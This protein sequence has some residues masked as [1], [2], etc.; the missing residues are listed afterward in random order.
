[1]QKKISIIVFLFL[2]IPVFILNAQ[3]GN[4]AG[5][6]VNKD[7]GDALP[8]VNVMI[9]ELE[10]GN[11]TQEGGRFLIE[12]VPTGTY[13]ITAS[14]IGYDRKTKSVTVNE[15]LTVTV[16]FELQKKDI[17]IS[18]IT[19]N[20]NRAKKRETPIAFNNVDKDKISDEYTTQDMPQ[21]LQ[22]VPGLFASSTG[23]GEAEINM[24]GFDADKIQVLINGVPVNDPESQEV[25]WS[26]WTGLSSTVQS[27]Q[28]QRGTGSSLY[29]SGAFGGSINIETVTTSPKRNFILRSSG[30]L[31]QSDTKTANGEG[32]L[33][34]YNPY[35]Y[36]VSL[37][38]ESG[39]LLE[40]RLNWSLML[41][42]KHGDSYIIN[43]N[44]DGYSIGLES[45]YLVG[46]HK[47]N[48]SFIGAP[49]EHNN[50]YFKSDPKLFDDLGR[51]Y[52]RNNTPYQENYYFKPQFSLRDEW[53]L[54]EDQLL[55]TNAFVTKGDGGGKYLSDTRGNK[56]VTAVYE[57]LGLI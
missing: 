2:L 37:K 16:N 28:V 21:L 15:N 18:G 43:T 36:N 57:S 27:V 52:N 33:T 6:V 39:G 14:I 8:Q 38:Y 22:E 44:Y 53:Q 56:L 13:E 41:E 35:N 20:A 11:L 31:Y 29:G 19:V 34:D 47:I 54:T 9:P 32:G 10:K 4:I 12:N 25:Y 3:T 26:N 50:V 49:Q 1:M 30:G 48:A 17:D 51:N 23:I 7:T 45:Q 24:R 55:M 5:R 40:D 46:N 42:K